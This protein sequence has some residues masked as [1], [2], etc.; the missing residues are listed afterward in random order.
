MLKYLQLTKDL[1]LTLESDRGEVLLCKWYRDAAFA[2]LSDM[3]RHSGAVL[4]LGKGAVNT[5]STKQNLNTRSST[6]AEVVAADDV[7]T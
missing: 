3:R 1:E 6:E 2:V 7:V 4:T 5:I